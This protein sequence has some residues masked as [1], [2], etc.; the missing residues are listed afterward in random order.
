MEVTTWL[1]TIRHFPCVSTEKPH[2]QLMP[3][4]LALQMGNRIT[5]KP[6]TCSRVFW[7][8]SILSCSSWESDRKPTKRK[9]QYMSQNQK[10]KVPPHTTFLLC[11]WAPIFRYK[12]H[13]TSFQPLFSGNTKFKRIE[14]CKAKKKLPNTFILWQTHNFNHLNK[15]LSSLPNQVWATLNVPDQTL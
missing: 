12:L 2:A 13:N 3:T 6:L 5:G 8:R 14:T 1:G 7:I 11:P 10:A 9:N 4:M 15:I